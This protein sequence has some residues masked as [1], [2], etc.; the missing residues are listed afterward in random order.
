[1]VVNDHF[2]AADRIT[3]WRLRYA[4]RNQPS[5]LRLFLMSTDWFNPL[6]VAEAYRL[7]YLWAQPTPLQALQLLDH[8]FPDPKVIWRLVRRVSRHISALPVTGW[9]IICPRSARSRCTSLTR[10]TTRNSGG[11][12][13]RYEHARNTNSKQEL[14]VLGVLPCAD[15]RIAPVF[16]VNAVASAA[17]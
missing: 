13:F 10:S 11:I 16:C 9:I 14:F 15:Q 12:C 6:A 1:V 17:S 3:V 4:L 8:R 2:S 5:V 7:L